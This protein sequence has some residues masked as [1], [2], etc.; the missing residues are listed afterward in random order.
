MSTQE[1]AWWYRMLLCLR[2]FSDHWRSLGPSLALRS[3]GRASQRKGQTMR[4][5]RCFQEGPGLCRARKVHC[6][7]VVLF[8]C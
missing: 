4:G 1:T 7:R 3:P 5:Q 2:Y 6:V 8:S